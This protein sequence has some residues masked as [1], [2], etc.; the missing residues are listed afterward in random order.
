M[1]Y[2]RAQMLAD[3]K[4]DERLAIVMMRQILDLKARG[5]PLP[6]GWR[7][8]R[9]LTLAHLNSVLNGAI[10]WAEARG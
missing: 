8:V 6:D 3:R 5:A 2:T 7:E 4:S 1:V 10:D 9:P